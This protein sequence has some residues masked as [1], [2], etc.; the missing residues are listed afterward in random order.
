MATADC[1][2]TDGAVRVVDVAVARR[3]RR[4]VARRA[5]APGRCGRRAGSPLY[6]SA[7]SNQRAFIA[8]T[9]SGSCVGEVRR[10][11]AVDLDVVELPDVLV[12]L[13]PAAQRR[14]HG[15]RQ[16]AVLVEGALAEHRVELGALR[17]A[18][19]GRSARPRSSRPRSGAARSP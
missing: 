11:R 5:S 2:G 16:P 6:C 18:R 4:W 19:P 7:S 12:E 9:R 13:A 15:A 1:S 17:R 8:C 10:L 3:V 14:V